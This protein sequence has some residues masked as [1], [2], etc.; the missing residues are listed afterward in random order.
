MIYLVFLNKLMT[1]FTLLIK[2]I[3]PEDYFL[4]KII[5]KLFYLIIFYAIYIL[6]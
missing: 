2:T 6:M 3:T 5:Y 4:T 1:H